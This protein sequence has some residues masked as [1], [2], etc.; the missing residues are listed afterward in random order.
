VLR[1]A[2]RKT[3]RSLTIDA[4]LVVETQTLAIVGR[5]GSGKSTLLQMIAGL[6][7]PDEGRIVLGGRVLFDTRRGVHVRPERRGIGY[8]FQNYA[9][10]PHLT[11]YGNVIYG[12]RHKGWTRPDIRKRAAAVMEQ[13]QI[14][15]LAACKPGRL[16]G[17]EQQRV[18]LARA[19]VMEPCLLLLDEPF[20]ALDVST[21]G[22]V[23]KELRNTLRALA[24]PTVFVTHDF[25]DAAGI[26][27]SIAVMEKGRIVQAGS[28]E[29][30]LDNPVSPFVAAFSGTN[31]FRGTVRR[32]LGS[33]PFAE[34]EVELEQGGVLRVRSS[35][36]EWRPGS[37]VV[38][39]VHPWKIVLRK[40]PCGSWNEWPGVVEQVV[41]RGN[42]AVVE[43]GGACS[44]RAELPAARLRELLLK[45]GDPVFTEIPGKDILLPANQGTYFR[46]AV[47]GPSEKPLPPEPNMV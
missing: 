5:S 1:V 8:V 15:H 35:G 36:R 7:R 10:F 44:L 25:E 46:Q 37:P 2:V 11:V 9:L 16:S 21:R 23:R 47:E 6:L 4:D 22:K 12:L 42:H 18:A 27:G 19:L 33:G 28:P 41:P 39:T 43:I 14:S 38:F 24:I 40:Q 17:G 13:L 26:A 20:S 30:L 32:L 3:F 45:P 31:F 29:D 34:L